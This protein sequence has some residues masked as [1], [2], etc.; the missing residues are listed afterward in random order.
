MNGVCTPL[1]IESCKVD[2]KPIKIPPMIASI[3]KCLLPKVYIV[4]GPS[5]VSDFSNLV[6]GAICA[7]K[8]KKMSKY[9]VI[10]SATCFAKGSH[11]AALEKKLAKAT[12][13]ASAPDCV[14]VSLWLECFGEAIA[15]S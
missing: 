9:T 14:P 6:A 1:P 13:S 3:K 10:D 15:K 7:S 2:S 5:G 12:F 11:S 8:G 4:V